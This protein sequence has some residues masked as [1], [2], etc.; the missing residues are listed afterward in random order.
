M[1]RIVD[2][3]FKSRI[4]CFSALL[5]AVAVP[6]YADVTANS[7]DNGGKIF[8]PAVENEV[9]EVTGVQVNPTDKGLEIILQTPKGDKLKVLPK[10]DGN[11]FVA[12]IPNSQLRLPKGDAFTQE[13]PAT[14]I[15]SITVTNLDAKSIRVTVMGET[16]LPKVELFDD[17]DG[18]VFGVTPIVS[19]TPAQQPESPKKPD[20]TKP[21]NTKPSESVAE[22]DEP[23][24][25]VVT[26]QKT[27]ENIQD[28]PLSVTAIS[29]KKSKMQELQIFKV[30]PI[31]PLIL[32]H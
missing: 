2:L 25:L 23:I 6:A 29:E 1:P 4:F 14:G 18:L 13:K 5:V 24:E 28:V 15:S 17:D 30:L 9:I 7:I 22:N 8:S 21:T 19:A 32:R 20:E 12:D 10:N 16:A 3:L 11:N 27:E 26:A 31:I